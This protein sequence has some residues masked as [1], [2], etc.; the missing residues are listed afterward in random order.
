M[1]TAI[2]LRNDGVRRVGKFSADGVL[3]NPHDNDLVPA[4]ALNSDVAMIPQN[5]WRVVDNR[6]SDRQFVG[7]DNN[8]VGVTNNWIKCLI[9]A[10]VAGDT[11]TVFTSCLDVVRLAVIHG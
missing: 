9:P 7:G 5:A 11:L 10:L 2:S 1:L 6:V 3:A 4:R 8:F